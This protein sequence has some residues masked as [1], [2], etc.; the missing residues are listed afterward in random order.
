MSNPT[1]LCQNNAQNGFLKKMEKKNGRIF[2]K[3]VLDS[4]FLMVFKDFHSFYEHGSKKW[5]S[6][7]G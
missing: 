4:G 6:E 7:V 1:N 3:D 5:C 2:F